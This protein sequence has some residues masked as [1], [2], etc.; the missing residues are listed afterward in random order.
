M[1]GPFF[2]NKE[3]MRTEKDPNILYG[4]D[5]KS[6]ITQGCASLGELIISDL[7]KGG[8]QTAFVSFAKKYVASLL[9]FCIFR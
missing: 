1:C 3:I 6:S 8:Q 2:L 4:G 5:Y 9:Q 7:K